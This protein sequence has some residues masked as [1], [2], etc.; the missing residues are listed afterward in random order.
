MAVEIL[1]N[2]KKQKDI[3]IESVQ[4]PTI[5]INKANMELLGIKLPESVLS[6]AKIK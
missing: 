3:K 6:K 4:M 1:K 2:G 5:S